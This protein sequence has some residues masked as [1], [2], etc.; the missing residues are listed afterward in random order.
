[1][2]S[3]PTPR[4]I[5][6]DSYDNL[7][8]YSSRLSHNEVAMDQILNVDYSSELDK[9]I[10][11]VTKYNSKA[12]F[13]SALKKFSAANPE[14]ASIICDYIMAEQTQMNIKE[15]T[16]EGK[17][18]VL[19]WL[20]SSFENKKPFRQMTKQD[21]LDYLNN[22]RKPVSEDP[23]HKW[24]GSYDGRQMIFN[25]FFRWL[26]NPDEPTPAKRTTPPCMVGVRRLP[27]QEK[28]PHKPSS[29]WNSREH[30]IFLKYCP[31]F[32]D[33][34][35]HAMANDMSARPHE[36]LNFRIKDIV[37]KVTEDGTNQYAEV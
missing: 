16:K 20:S 30:A 37:F 3:N 2:G 21:I 9:K 7:F 28:S 27:R 32:R 6:G 10:D 17:I 14:N 36:I 13:R 15:S 8:S 29:L 31:S 34:C 19:I 11:Y 23:T 26:Y 18:K 1:V 35:Y 5:L 33:R 24:I 25:K 12:Y 4:A 22:L